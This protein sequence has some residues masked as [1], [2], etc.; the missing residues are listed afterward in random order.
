MAH[1]FSKAIDDK[2]DLWILYP[3]CSCCGREG[4]YR[5]D[6]TESETLDRYICLGRQM[7]ALQD[8]FPKVPSWIRSGSIDKYSDGFC[9]CPECSG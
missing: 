3:K 2:T 5:C 9:I 8:L 4:E 1:F 6:E 7:G